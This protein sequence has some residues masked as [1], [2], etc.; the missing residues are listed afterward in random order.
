MEYPIDVFA[1]TR[2]LSDCIMRSEQYQKMKN[3][4]CIAMANEDAAALVLRYTA[5]DEQVKQ[6]MLENDTDFERIKALNATMSE[7]K[8]EM[9]MYTEL[10]ELARTR[11]EF[12]SFMQQIVAML[13]FLLVDFPD[14]A[15][16]SCDKCRSCD[17]C[18]GC[19]G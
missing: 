17:G 2:E 9:S 11:Q 6:M 18:G 4:E 19:E 8:N 16:S 5:Y 14:D 1:K 12:A 10:V 13:K 3:A 15:F 7:I